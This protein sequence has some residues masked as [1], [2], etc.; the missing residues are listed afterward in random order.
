[1]KLS[2]VNKILP[3]LYAQTSKQ[4][5]HTEEILKIRDVFPSLKASKID[6]IQRNVKGGD[7][8]KPCIKM[9]TKGLSRKQVIVPMNSDVIKRFMNESSNHVANLNRI[10]KNIKINVMVD[11]I[12]SDPLNIMIITSKITLTSNLQTIKNY[13]KTTNSIDSDGIKVS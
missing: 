1:M 11:F 6:N 3:K 8:S 7:N 9:T 10:L 12:H 4:A 2:P 13:V 5:S